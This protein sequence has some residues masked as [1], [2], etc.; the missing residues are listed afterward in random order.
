MQIYRYGCGTISTELGKTG[1]FLRKYLAGYR[2]RVGKSN[3]D[4]GLGC[5]GEKVKIARNWGAG[6]NCFGA[7]PEWGAGGWSSS[8]LY[9]PLVVFLN[10]APKRAFRILEK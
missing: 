9:C 5:V 10:M 3:P 8:E 6:K 4:R 1:T 2:Y 7:S